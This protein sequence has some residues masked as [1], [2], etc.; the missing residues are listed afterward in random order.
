MSRSCWPACPPCQQPH[1]ELRRRSLG[2]AGGPHQGGGRHQR[3][4]LQ[5]GP[6]EA[7][8]GKH[9]AQ[10]RVREI[11]RVGARRYGVFAAGGQRAG[12]LARA[13][14][15]SARHDRS[16][17]HGHGG[18][19]PPGAREGGARRPDGGVPGFPRPGQRRTIDDRLLQGSQDALPGD[20]FQR[21]VPVAYGGSDAGAGGTRGDEPR[22]RRLAGAG[23]RRSH[24][25]DTSPT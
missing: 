15:E 10:W 20:H 4:V 3:N 24:R 11:Q 16:L 13:S 5:Q 12:A 17:A 22:R 25:A 1:R 7:G 19:A 14:R 23:R 8:H 18:P 21:A 9:G 2:G 6:A